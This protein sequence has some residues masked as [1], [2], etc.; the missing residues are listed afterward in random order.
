[1]QGERAYE[2]TSFEHLALMVNG[3]LF[4]LAFDGGRLQQLVVVVVVNVRHHHRVE[5]LH[6]MRRTIEG[7]RS[8]LASFGE[9]ELQQ[10]M[11]GSR[12]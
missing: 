7:K 10:K 9:M 5:L 12:T 6:L 3:V 4:L 11:S 2:P 8:E 1:M